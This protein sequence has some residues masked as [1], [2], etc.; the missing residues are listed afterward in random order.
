VLLIVTR[1]ESSSPRFISDGV[2]TAW[3]QQLS[4]RMLVPLPP[5]AI[6]VQKVR[7]GWCGPG[8]DG[9][10]QWEPFALVKFADVRPRATTFAHEMGH[11]FDHQVLAP[12]GFRSDFAL[13]Q[14]NDWVT[15]LSEEVFASAYNLCA[16]NRNLTRAVVLIGEVRWTPSQHRRACA[17]IRLAARAKP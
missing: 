11:V 15:P 17:L 7:P 8:S 3:L 2:D 6:V 16:W 12:R 10:M 1:A 9:C 13:I 14:G 5:K 4:A